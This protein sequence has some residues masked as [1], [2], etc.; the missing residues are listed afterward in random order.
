MTI[1]EMTAEIKK[2]ENYYG[3]QMTVDENEIWYDNLKE[4]SIG[5]FRLIVAESYKKCKYMPKLSEIWDIH[6]EMPYVEPKKEEEKKANCRICGNSGYVIYVKEYKGLE[7]DTVA[8]C[9]CGR[10]KPYDGQA[11]SDESKRNNYYQ[12]T[13]RE[14]DYRK[15]EPLTKE[16]LADTINKLKSLGIANGKILESARNLYKRL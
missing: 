13:S 9:E 15:T 7:Y 11:L 8:V 3:K 2:L 16:Q 14:V 10:K 12:K 1:D 5:R 4:L 6:K